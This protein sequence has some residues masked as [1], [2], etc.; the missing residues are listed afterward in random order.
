VHWLLWIDHGKG[1]IT[2]LSVSSAEPAEWYKVERYVESRLSSWL[3][4]VPHHEK[5]DAE[6]RNDTA[7]LEKYKEQEKPDYQCDHHMLDDEHPC[8]RRLS[9]LT[10]YDFSVHSRPHSKNHEGKEAF[11]GFDIVSPEVHAHF[12]NVLLAVQM[13]HCHKTCHKYGHCD[14]C[15]F[16][17]PWAP[18]TE[19][20]LETSSDSKGRVRSKVTT[21][22]NNRWVN[23][24]CAQVQCVCAAAGNTDAS[25]I[26]DRY[27]ACVYCASY[28]S[29]AEEPDCSKM[30]SIIARALSLRVDPSA[31]DILRITINALLRSTT[32]GAT[33]AAWHLLNLPFVRKTKT[34]VNVN[35]LP[36]SEISSRLRTISE[37]KAAVEE[38]GA[39]AT[40]GDT[41]PGTNIGRRFAYEALVK[42]QLD[43][44][45]SSSKTPDGKEVSSNGIVTFSALL[46]RYRLS[47]HVDRAKCGADSKADDADDI[48]DTTDDSGLNALFG[49]DAVCEP[50]IEAKKRRST[51]WKQLDQLLLVDEHGELKEGKDKHGNQNPRHF[52]VGG[53]R[54]QW[55]RDQVVI[56]QSP[57]VPFNDDDDR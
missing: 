56:S 55:M 39:E 52:V 25:F 32:V 54:F 24:H 31:K 48:G 33:Q 4:E 44:L 1:G 43:I 41:S 2:P 38:D 47:K 42:N 20:R 9:E 30:A 46:S 57:Y 12:R 3:P 51:S 7:L 11:A 6:A 21:P 34:V 36:R 15:R 13:H 49:Y 18:S 29:K 22:R 50:R 35:T 37:L 8:A 19:V 28:A 17:A 27:G 26:G 14:D 5:D 40:A 53:T 23:R 10:T 16:G 45:R